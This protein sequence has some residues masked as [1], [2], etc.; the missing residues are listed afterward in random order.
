MP[1]C[2]MDYDAI[3]YNGADCNIVIQYNIG[4]I[5]H[6][7]MRYD[8]LQYNLLLKHAVHYS[9]MQHDTM[10]LSICSCNIIQYYT[11]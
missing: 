5:S 10:R 1:N 9:T 4:I 7:A 11:I 6:D 3:R 8:E 2:A